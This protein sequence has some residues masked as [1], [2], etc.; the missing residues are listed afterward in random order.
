MLYALLSKVKDSHET[1]EMPFC[2]A[3]PRFLFA[4]LLIPK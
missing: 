3:H 4:S 2:W 1:A